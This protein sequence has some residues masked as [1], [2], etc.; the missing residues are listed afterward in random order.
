MCQK[1]L[2]RKNYLHWRDEERLK[3]FKFRFIK[4]LHISNLY[5][6]KI[7]FKDQFVDVLINFEVTWL[8]FRK[9]K[10]AEKKLAKKKQEKMHR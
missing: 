1:N 9:F 5:S 7:K 6:E 10:I 3:F 2:Y 4:K 8:K